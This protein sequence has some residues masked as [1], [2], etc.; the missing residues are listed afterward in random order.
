MAHRREEEEEEVGPATQKLRL[1]TAIQI[2]FLFP[3]SRWCGQANKN[4]GNKPLS[5]TRNPKLK[6]PNGKRLT[7]MEEGCFLFFALNSLMYAPRTHLPPTKVESSAHLQPETKSL[8]SNKL[9]SSKWMTLF[10]RVP[11]PPFSHHHQFLRLHV[12]FR[13]VDFVKKEET[14]GRRRGAILEG[15]K[16]IN[17]IKSKVGDLVRQTPIDHLRASSLILCFFFPVQNSLFILTL[18]MAQTRSVYMALL[19]ICSSA[20]SGVGARTHTSTT[21]IERKKKKRLN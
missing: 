17:G 8:Q 3:S 14:R 5:L 2:F 15:L 4:K 16:G 18:I 11:P 7:D 6:G 9:R 12:D 20:R 13:H 21:R 10:W 19:K 1:H